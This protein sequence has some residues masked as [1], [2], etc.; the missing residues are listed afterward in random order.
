MVSI[1]CQGTLR[2]TQSNAPASPA[3]LHGWQ[4]S[5][6]YDQPDIVLV[7]FPKQ[8]VTA[9]P[10][11]D[12]RTQQTDIYLQYMAHLETRLAA[13]DNLKAHFLRLNADGNEVDDLCVFHPNAAA[14][15]HYAETAVAFIQQQLPAWAQGSDA[16]A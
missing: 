2:I 3:D 14:H 16:T 13:N 11:M 7:T 5:D 9:S 8:K 4:V 12:L 1:L 15:V 6:V 10:G